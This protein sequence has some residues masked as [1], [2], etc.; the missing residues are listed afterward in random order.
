MRAKIGH[1][2]IAAL[3]S[4]SILW[5]DKVRG[6]NA[7]RQFS[8]V[9][10]YSVFYRT[11]DG[12]QRWHKI[13]RHTIFT[14]D[15]ARKEAIRILRDVALGNDPSG[16][17]QAVRNSM[18]VAQLCDL[19]QTDMQSDKINGKKAT[20]ISS[21]VNRIKNHIKPKL[22]NFKVATITPEQI[23]HF[24][25]EL[26]IGSAR[27]IMALT[28]TIFNFAV[29]RKLRGDNPVS[30]VEK[31]SEVN[32]TR[33]LSNSEYQQL[34]AAI[35]GGTALSP[36]VADIFL[37]LAVTGFRSGEA[38]LLK[39]EELDLER[40]CADLSDTK[41]GKSVRPLSSAAINIVQRQERKSEYVFAF[42]KGQ[43]ISNVNQHWGKLRLDKTITPHTLRHSFAS[44]A[45][46]LGLA[47]S[48]IAGLL[49]HA[50]SSITSRYIHLD[51]A[52]IVAANEVAGETMRLM[53]SH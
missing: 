1:R 2:A 32:K 20:T 13:G 31:P 15:L 41:T 42:L 27:R 50:R 4:N 34:W 24:M 21:D 5:D 35:N 25:H 40:C 18:T 37:F 9:I 8:D 12:I 17:R 46:D 10:T 52:L 51:K 28:G 43:P 53:Q 22:G 39:W 11:R 30:G 47:D 36:V 26:S 49:G 33:R 14:P 19:Y 16:E 45:G 23:E 3:Q 44:L 29:K 6:F 48:T 7:R 38:R